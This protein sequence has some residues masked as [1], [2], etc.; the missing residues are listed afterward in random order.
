MFNKIKQNLFEFLVA[1]AVVS[2]FGLAFLFSF[3]TQ[4]D[5][6]TPA[7]VVSRGGTGISTITEG[8]FFVGSTIDHT[9]ATSGMLMNM[10]TG[11]ITIAG[12][13]D[14]GS[15]T[16]SAVADGDLTVTGDTGLGTTS[17]AT[18]LD[19]YSNATTTETID[20][21]HASRGACTK[22]KDHDGGGYTYC[23]YLNGAETCSAISCE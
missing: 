15:V 22:Y 21:S 4:V 5:S 18:T 7:L 11:D 14:V 1:G 13:L 20:S 12:A 10:T 2:I 17:P 23:V 19:V 6:A 16:I 9:V 8:Q 3:P